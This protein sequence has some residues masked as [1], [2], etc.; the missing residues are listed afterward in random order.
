MQ[1]HRQLRKMLGDTL[2]E[3]INPIQLPSSTLE[4]GKQNYY[5][6]FVVSS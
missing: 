5:I 1:S 2:D 6:L 4:H 3:K